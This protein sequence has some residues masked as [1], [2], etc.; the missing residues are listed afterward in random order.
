VEADVIIVGAGLAGLTAARELARQDLHPLVLE[1]RDRTGGRAYCVEQWDRVL[2]LGGQ[3]LH[4]MQPHIWSEVTRY[5]C[6]IYDRPAIGTSLVRV[7]QRVLRYESGI[8]GGQ[9]DHALGQLYARSGEVFERPY[10]PLAFKGLPDLDRVSVGDALDALELA[11][12]IRAAVE[13]TL[14]VNFNAPFQDGALT[15]GLRR[16]A[17]SLNRAGLSPEVVRWRIRGGIGTLVEAITADARARG[18][19]VRL[20]APVGAIS[21]T[22]EGV[23]VQLRSGEA[24]AAR[25]AIV[26]TPLPALAGI[27]FTPDLNHGKRAIIS[28]GL[29]PRGVML[30]VRLANQDEEFQ[31]YAPP[32]HPLSYIRSD[33]RSNGDLI[34]QAFGSEVARLD[35]NDREAVERAVRVWLPGAEVRDTL[36]HDWVND[37]FS[38]L[39]WAMLRPGQLSRYLADVQ[40]C[41]GPVVFAGSDYASG[42]AGYFDGA[43]ESAIVGARATRAWLDGSS[44]T[45]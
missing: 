8:L 30:W 33:G 34:A 24:L 29:M 12:E 39:S 42:W 9:L 32:D 14:A 28:E 6:E 38:R 20:S 23:R 15:Q 45:S 22:V 17:L 7:G 13:A 25:A 43:V 11:P 35:P 31:G 16:V 41:E 4:W 36:G 37:E 1:A 2:E 10:E 18:A 19:D 5:G 44:A 27:D 26:T 21:R 3:A 40:R